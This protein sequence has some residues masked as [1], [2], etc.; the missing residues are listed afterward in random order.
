MQI[1]QRKQLINKK[2]PSILFDKKEAA[3]KDRKSIFEIGQ[4]GL[5]E[6]I[7]FLIKTSIFSI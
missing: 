5:N 6:L 1:F 4:N 7:S 3:T 2:R